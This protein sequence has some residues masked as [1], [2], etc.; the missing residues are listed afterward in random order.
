M[1][2]RDQGA[3]STGYST[4]SSVTSEEIYAGEP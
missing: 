2:W 4:R 1:V 3:I